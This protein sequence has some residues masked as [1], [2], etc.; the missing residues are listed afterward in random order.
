MLMEAIQLS[1]KVRDHACDSL[2]LVL[3]EWMNSM[4]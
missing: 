3:V 2:I 4:S 1:M